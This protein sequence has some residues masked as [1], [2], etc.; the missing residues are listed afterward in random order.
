[1]Q[2]VFKRVRE[3]PPSPRLF[4]PQLDVNWE[5]AILGCLAREPAHRYRDADA[6]V[7]ALRGDWVAPAGAA[8]ARQ[9]RNHAYLGWLL[10]AMLLAAAAVV[11]LTL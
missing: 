8:A 4:A 11:V 10:V 7:R 9:P 3:D 2:A 6:V 1:L 5:R